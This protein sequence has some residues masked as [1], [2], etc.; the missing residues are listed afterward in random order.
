M[1]NINSSLN[2]LRSSGLATA[3]SYAVKNAQSIISAIFGV[4]ISFEDLNADL[5]F[6]SLCQKDGVVGGMLP[7]EGGA[8]IFYPLTKDAFKKVSPSLKESKEKTKYVSFSYIGEI[9]YPDAS[10]VEEGSEEAETVTILPNLLISGATYSAVNQAWDFEAEKGLV[11]KVFLAPS[12]LPDPGMYPVSRISIIKAG[13]AVIEIGGVA[14]FRCSEKNVPLLE[15]GAVLEVT[16]D[17]V[18]LGNEVVSIGSLSELFNYEFK[19]DQVFLASNLTPLGKTSLKFSNG[20]TEYWANRAIKDAYNAL[21]PNFPSD[22][23]CE[24]VGQ[25]EKDGKITPKL[26]IIHKNHSQYNLK[27]EKAVILVPVPT[28]K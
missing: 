22:L 16:A 7:T 1:A 25:N 15:V 3:D 24:V 9:P 6:P 27:V 17:S 8:Y 10:D 23:L 5:R 2:I 20:E 12:V 13:G 26:A 14:S 19:K 4:D 21:A 18:K 11:Q 28:G